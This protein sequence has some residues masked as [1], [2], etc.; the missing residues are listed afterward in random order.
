MS[1]RCDRS[2]LWSRLRLPAALIAAALAA[3]VPT[4]A[5][6]TIKLGA[7]LPMTGDLQAFGETT[8]NGINLAIDHIN[9]NGGVLDG[10]LSLSVGDTQTAAQPSIDAA[11]KLVSIEKVVAVLG[12]LSSGNTI[13]VAETI[14]SSASIPQI[15]NA[16]TSP[17]IT[18]L[19][20]DDFLFRT[21]PSDAFQGVA[22]AEIVS[23]KGMEKLAAIYINNDYGEG[24][25]ESFKTAF[26][27][28]GGT[29]T[30][31]VPYEGGKASYRSELGQLARGGAEAL[32]LIGYP[33][34]GITILKQALEEGFFTD[35]VFTDGM[36]APEVIEQIGAEFLNGAFGTVPQA[37][38]D[39]DSYGAFVAA[40]E[41]E[42]GELP[43]KPY[44]DGAYD[45]V[46][47]L[48][49]AMEKAGSTDGAAIRDAIRDVANTPGEPILPGEW[50]KA[51]AAIAEGKDIDYV[52]AAGAVDFDDNGDVAGAFAHWAIEDGE[53]VTVEVFEPES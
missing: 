31:S 15:S 39:S 25:A 32:V 8:L 18:G 46:M 3:A 1:C 30:A 16:S 24:L 42:Y 45:A 28:E 52:G 33:E 50:A 36:K 41:A 37:I 14:T 53:L 38:T 40:Y 20:D 4:S 17:T 47:V 27:A 44:I 9:E 48:A 51:K 5:Q 19:S 21:V 43:P 2:Q 35:F 49:L 23:E 7:L 11:Q 34:N 12:A 10:S 22:L 13:P 6:E 26:E 29:V